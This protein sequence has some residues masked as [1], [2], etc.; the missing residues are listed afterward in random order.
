M[1]EVPEAL[2]RLVRALER[3]NVKYVVVGGVVAVHYGR[4]RTWT[5]WSTG[6]KSIPSR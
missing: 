5:W 6:E 1:E 3:A 4:V 2:Q